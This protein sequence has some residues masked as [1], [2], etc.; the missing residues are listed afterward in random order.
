MSRAVEEASH[1]IAT[2]LPAPADR[3][4]TGLFDLAA[5]R[6]ENTLITAEATLT[7]LLERL[8]PNTHPESLIALME[9][10]PHG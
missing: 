1:I 7:H 10:V 8:G 5:A 4:T 6:E 2:R 3:R 9:E